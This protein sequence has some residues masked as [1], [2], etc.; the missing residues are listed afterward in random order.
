MLES[1]QSDLLSLKWPAPPRNILLVK[2]DSA[3]DVTESLI[4]LVKYGDLFRH[5]TWPSINHVS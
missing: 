3:P 4:E 1:R 5:L 2:K